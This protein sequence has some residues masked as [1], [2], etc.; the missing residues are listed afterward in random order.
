MFHDQ[1]NWDQY[2]NLTIKYSIGTIEVYEAFDRNRQTNVIV[3]VFRTDKTISNELKDDLF[4]VFSNLERHPTVAHFLDVHVSDHSVI[5]VIE[6]KSDLKQ[7]L[8]VKG[9]LPF[10]EVYYMITRVS[11]VI[12]YIHSIGLAHTALWPENILL[13]KD[14]KQIQVSG[15]IN[16]IAAKVSGHI[17]TADLASKS[18]YLPQNLHKGKLS[19][20]QT[21]IYSL[22]IVLY[23]MLTGRPPT[24]ED[25]SKAKLTDTS[26]IP[27]EVLQVIAKAILAFSGESYSSVDKFWDD[28]DNAARNYNSILKGTPA[29]TAK[30]TFINSRRSLAASSRRD[31]VELL[32]VTALSAISTNLLASLFTGSLVAIVLAAAVGIL[33]PLANILLNNQERG[34]KI[35]WLI[36][37]VLMIFAVILSFSLSTK[38]SAQLASQEIES[39]QDLET[40][41]VETIISQRTSTVQPYVTPL[42]T[43]ESIPLSQQTTKSIQISPTVSSTAQPTKL[44]TNITVAEVD[45]LCRNA[46][47]D[48]GSATITFDLV[49]ESYHQ[50]STLAGVCIYSETRGMGIDCAVVGKD[51]SDNIPG[52]AEYS[53]SGQL[54]NQFRFRILGVTLFDEDTSFQDALARLPQPFMSSPDVAI[55]IYADDTYFVVSPCDKVNFQLRLVP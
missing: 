41:K 47:G 3:E 1:T 53:I 29:N 27:S 4:S 51:V 24:V 46:H 32:L 34:S 38:Q 45:Y 6:H 20:E 23:E 36:G 52:T 12:A 21:D 13:S 54:M 26:S 35:L 37:V 40:P 42:Q 18:V 39:I 50:L 28:F 49:D 17:Q 10:D 30:Y 11:R 44:L 55:D 16:V 5:I 48:A 22:G 14:R 15:F 43:L 33:V 31:R 25:F 2:N 9:K 8:K 19:Y 7:V